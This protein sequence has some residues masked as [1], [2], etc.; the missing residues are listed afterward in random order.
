M[1]S[2]SPLKAASEAKEETVEKS[3]RNLRRLTAT[4]TKPLPPPSHG[5]IPP[6]L[7]CAILKSNAIRNSLARSQRL[8]FTSECRSVYCPEPTRSW[9]LHKFGVRPITTPR[10][11]IYSRAG[12][13]ISLSL[14]CFSA[15]D[16]STVTTQLCV[17]G[18]AVLFLR[19][20]LERLLVFVMAF[21]EFH[22]FS[23]FI[24]RSPR[25]LSGFS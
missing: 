18:N 17:K 10:R 16:D 15:H 14:L 24:Y 2:L 9:H 19:I 4:D 25:V 11:R 8:P 3:N 21:M 6:C 13:V 20:S 7:L 12:E 22:I 1:Q 23:K 5:E